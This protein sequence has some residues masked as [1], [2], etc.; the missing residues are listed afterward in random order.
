MPRV[1]W[2]LPCLFL[3][4]ALAAETTPT[5]VDTLLQQLGSKDPKTRDA[6]RRGL[7]S[8][9]PDAL[10][11]LRKALAHPDL[12]VRKRVGDVIPSIETAELVKPKLVTLKAERK[13]ARQLLEEV[14]RQTGYK[15]D[16][17]N[18]SPS[19]VFTF[20]LEG[21]PFWRA[22]DEIGRVSGLTPVVGYG[23]ERI[24]FQKEAGFPSHVARD[25][26]FRLV[27]TTFEYHRSLGFGRVGE[28]PRPAERSETLTLN[29][30]LHAEPKLP[31][32]AVGEAIIQEA[33]D[34]E[35]RS[36]MPAPPAP[37]G[38]ER[39]MVRRAARYG[40]GSASTS[41]QGSIALGRPAERARGVK[42]LRALL[43]V[44]LLAEQKPEVVTDYVLEVKK[45][46]FKVGTT[47]FEIESCAKT[48]N[49]QYRLKTVIREESVG[50]DDYTWMNSLY[51]RVEL[52]DEKGN[53]LA[54]YGSSWSHS[55]T[56][57]V[58]VT[59]T[60]SSGAAVGPPRKLIYH[61]WKTLSYHVKAELRDLP[62][63]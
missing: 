63:P 1:A 50:Q 15:L 54:N 45:K 32:L 10:P 29:Y 36:L 21:V 31:L 40:N 9:G 7:E 51:R 37:V 48:E 62:L 49:N 46:T 5:S 18:D 4:C 3:G 42:L 27:P 33:L 30:A 25:G 43:P 57:H 39:V 24:R 11:A 12:E 6:A 52:V 19:Q 60:Y 47:T 14:S 44:T 41:V 20:D 2:L 61:T 8:L 38:E 17:W 34:D 22:I 16:A 58:N 56:N 55:A 26:C 23:D 35:G 28:Q 53:K 13:T 59:F